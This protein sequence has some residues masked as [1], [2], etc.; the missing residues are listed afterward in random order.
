MGLSKSRIMAGLQCVKRLHLSVHR[1]ELE[2][3]N[4]AAE[5]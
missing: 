2:E 3:E 4:A 5:A 1:P